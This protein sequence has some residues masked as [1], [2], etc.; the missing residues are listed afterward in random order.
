MYNNYSTTNNNY[1]MNGQ[2]FQTHFIQYD[3]PR[4]ACIYGNIHEIHAMT[5]AHVARYDEKQRKSIVQTFRIPFVG[6]QME[7]YGPYD[8]NVTS[9]DFFFF[10]QG[11]LDEQSFYKFIDCVK[12]NNSIVDGIDELRRNR[13]RPFYYLDKLPVKVYRHNN[14]IGFY[15]DWFRLSIDTPKD[16]PL[17]PSELTSLWALADYFPSPMKFLP[18]DESDDSDKRLVGELQR[19]MDIFNRD[20]IYQYNSVAFDGEYCYSE[21]L[22]KITMSREDFFKKFPSAEPV[23]RKTNNKITDKKS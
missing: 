15:C 21:E 13:L 3:K 12:Q 11:E 18:S 10:N 6:P 2:Q 23:Y 19:L 8:N 22:G 4:L 17:N 7:D 16:K 14:T 9:E 1:L 5:I 20:N